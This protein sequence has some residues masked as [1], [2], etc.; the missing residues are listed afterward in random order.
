MVSK[1]SMPTWFLMF[2]QTLT[3]GAGI[4][5]DSLEPGSI[6]SYKELREQ[7][8]RNFSQQRKALKNPN[9]ILHI[10]R[11]DD[12]KVEQFMDRYVAESM[13]IKGVP[14][15][16]KISGFINGMRFSQLMEKLGEDFP[17]FRSAN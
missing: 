12:E 7:F 1:L 17:T 6:D 11:R 10:R 3:G 9:E 8:L 15:V 14:E 5:F 13:N 16:M 4:W 2:P